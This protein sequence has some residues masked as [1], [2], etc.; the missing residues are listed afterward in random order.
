MDYTLAIVLAVIAGSLC[1][2]FLLTPI[3]NQLVRWLHG[4]D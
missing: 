3:T 4:R 1:G 2:W